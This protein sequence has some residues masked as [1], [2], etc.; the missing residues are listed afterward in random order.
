MN[1]VFGPTTLIL[2]F[3]S[4][5]FVSNFPAYLLSLRV[6]I[7]PWHFWGASCL[8][9]TF[10]AIFSN[11]QLRLNANSARYVMW[12]GLFILV[13]LLSLLVVDR[14]VG[15]VE[16]FIQ[17]GWNF[18]IGSSLLLL[19]RTPAQ[20]N[21]CG[22]GVVVAVLTLAV[23]TMME[24][25]DPNF[26]VLVDRL[27]EDQSEV[28]EVNRAGAFYGNPN[29]NG[30]ALVLGMFVGQFFLPRTLRFWFA[31]FVGAAVFCTVSRSSL[32]LWALALVVSF[33]FG[34]NSSRG[35]LSKIVGLGIVCGLGYLLVSGAVPGILMYLGLDELMNKNMMARLSEN[36]FT[37]ED[38]S[39]D[40]R[41]AAALEATRL[42]ADHP[43]LGAGLGTS[44][45]VEGGIGAHN[46]HLKIAGELGAVGYVVWIGMLVL[47]VL[48]GSAAAISFTLLYLFVCLFSHTMF[49]YSAYA[50][51]LPLSL[52]LLPDMLRP[53][54]RQK[55]KRR[56]RRKRSAEGWHT[57][58]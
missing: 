51:L 58:S 19:V 35:M 18:A 10:L 15:A 25:A 57:G 1:S 13:C 7:V 42:F 45:N 3:F 31:L 27:F 2:F 40:G 6:G 41:L 22:W 53:I 46:Q 50:I 20:I 28:G 9:C 4:A 49:A 54:G 48:S 34:F 29:N 43:V 11:R 24:F 23:L 30:A 5:V 12:Y 38:S 32:V 21:A 47:A 17:Y 37:Q 16:Q 55:R 8:I 26:Q 44:E 56:R 14:G 36:F 33:L 39:T 52:A